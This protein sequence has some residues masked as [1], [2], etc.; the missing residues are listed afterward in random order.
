MRRVLA[1]T[2]AAVTALGLAACDWPGSTSAHAPSTSSSTGSS[3]SSSTS[4]TVPRGSPPPVTQSQ[5][6]DVSVCSKL[7]PAKVAK[8]AGDDVTP[9]LVHKRMVSVVGVP[10]FDV[11]TVALQRGA[12]KSSYDIG[13]GVSVAN[14]GVS[15]WSAKVRGGAEAAELQGH[16]L[17]ITRSAT[18][19]RYEV[20]IG[21]KV[22]TVFGPPGQTRQQV[23]AELKLAIPFVRQAYA[24]R[25]AITVPAC[26]RADAA[27]ADALG[28]AAMVRRD[29]GTGGDLTCGWSTETAYVRTYADSGPADW[30]IVVKA[31]LKRRPTSERVFGVGADAV[32]TPPTSAERPTIRV[33]TKQRL[34]YIEGSAKRDGKQVDKAA[35]VAVAKAIIGSY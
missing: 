8:A 33:A 14:W 10:T 30:P 11:C 7:D 18:G 2:A 27:A 26:G 24:A 9:R 17:L 5:R 3:I 16:D 31:I 25:L 34:V 35:L 28:R 4:A 1:V 29:S 21:A 13:F 15:Q 32:Y 19:T 6:W 20:L 12:E 22:L 23:T